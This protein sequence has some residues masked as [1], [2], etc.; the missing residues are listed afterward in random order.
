MNIIDCRVNDAD[1]RLGVVPPLDFSW[2]VRGGSQR[3]YRIRLALEERNGKILWDSGRVESTQSWR[4]P[5]TGTPPS[6][7]RLYFRVDIWGT[8]GEDTAEGYLETAPAA[9]DWKG[10]WIA[11]SS[12]VSNH[13]HCRP[14]PCLR[15]RFTLK[16]R[17]A[18]GLLY[19]CG[20]GY[21]RFY[22]N[23]KE[24]GDEVLSP[25]FTAYDKRVLFRTYDITDLLRKGENVLGAM[26]GNGFYNSFT[27]DVWDFHHA[28][29]RHHPKL[30]C[31]LR[32]EYSDGDAELVVS[33]PDWKTHPGPVLF[34]A[35]RNGEIYD[36]R[37]ALAG[38]CEPGYDDTVWTEALVVNPPGGRLVSSVEPPIRRCGRVPPVR[39]LPVGE[40]V[41]VVDFGRNL[42]GWIHLK[43]KGPR[44]SALTVRY[45]EALDEKGRLDT[46]CIDPY[47][48]SGEFQ[49][50]R[51][52]LAGEPSGEEWEPGF[53][54]HGFRYAQIESEGTEN[55]SAEAVSVHTDLPRIG[56]F[57]CGDERINRIEE[58]AAASFRRN[59]HS[60]PTDCP[61]REKNGWT[62][63]AALS[64][65]QSLY[66]YDVR[67]N[68]RKWM[69]DLLD[70]QRPSG[71]LPGIV[72]TSGWGYNWGSGPAWDNALFEIPWQCYRMGGD[73]LLLERTAEAMERSLSYIGRHTR[74]EDNGTVAFGLGDWCPPETVNGLPKCPAG[75]TDTGYYYTNVHRMAAIFE[76]LD[77][78]ERAAHYRRLAGRIAMDFRRAYVEEET[79]W[80]SGHCQT[81]Q[82]CALFHPGLIPDSDL[83]GRIWQRLLEEIQRCGLA[84]DC[85]ILGNKYLY[86][87][88]SE[89]GRSD[90][91]YRLITRADPPS[92]LYWLEQGDTLWETWREGAYTSRNH[93][94]FSCISDWFWM[95]L[96]GL[97]PLEPGFRRF[98]LC[99][100]PPAELPWADLRHDCPYGPILFSYCREEERT[101]A[102]LEVPSGC[103]AAVDFSALVG[104]RLKTS[105]M[106][107]ICKPGLYRFHIKD[108]GMEIQE[109][110]LP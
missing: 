34:N 70:A 77:Q 14:A 17:P 105:S 93:H 42:A 86:A 91:A 57:R 102:A 63:D 39:I 5:W 72:P 25:G 103:E 106:T 109:E 38:W 60:I 64:A 11:D 16:E 52:I 55:W 45:G 78:P 80:V 97:T 29:W 79:G 56:W 32:A 71:Q 12:E 73:R 82:A 7:T 21:G 107:A 22:L 85:G 61:Q 96:G 92:F 54:Y 46:S 59:F 66:H 108:S 2:R 62:G 35:L 3:A 48:Q 76:A 15:R 43:A 37:C 50:D 4:I 24:I 74:D 89:N 1:C 9:E 49:T 41:K 6:G 20:L 98:S 90:L 44:G 101:T 51:Y 19:A 95:Y 10:R 33:G 110:R 100:R 31:Q 65:L 88:L 99:P 40:T 68:Y 47:V 67:A 8:G 30:L 87:V 53:T 23:G 94:M 75:V 69:G 27:E 83:R 36:A 28:P 13:R 58:A 18:R 81:G 84:P 104:M 26:L